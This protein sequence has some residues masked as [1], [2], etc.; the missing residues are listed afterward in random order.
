M[1]NRLSISNI[2]LIEKLDLEFGHG[3]N[4]L[5]GETGAGKS[6]LMDALA[7]ALGARSDAGLVRHGCDGASVIAEFDYIPD[8]VRGILDENGIDTAD[9]VLILRRTLTTDGKSRA[10][11]NDT[12]V[13][14]KLLKQIGDLLV[15]IHG[16]FENHSLLD[17]TTHRA[18]LDEFG[19]TAIDGYG[20]LLSDVARTY[21]AYHAADARLRE[22]NDMLDRAAAER[23]FLE[24]N[25][26]ELRS[27][28]PM[29]GEE[30]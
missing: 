11:I 16:Q 12:P 22:L 18:T 26:S 9:D 23:E 10:W 15:E 28:N 17:A 2:V 5:T 29:V 25:V 27:L 24:H 13:S 3:L 14:I 1:L 8:V 20:E 30:E 21:D 6:I 7:L 4:I 19:M